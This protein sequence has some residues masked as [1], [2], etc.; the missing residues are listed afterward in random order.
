MIYGYARVSTAG[1]CKDGN[2]LEDQTKALRVPGDRHGGLHRKVHGKAPIFGTF[3][4]VA[5]W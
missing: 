4:E 5:G 2:S 3:S 1:Q